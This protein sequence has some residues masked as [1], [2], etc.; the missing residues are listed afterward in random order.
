M[1]LDSSSIRTSSKTQMTLW[2]AM[3]FKTILPADPG[4]EDVDDPSYSGAASD[5]HARQQCSVDASVQKY[6]PST[7]G[8]G[9]I[10]TRTICPIDLTWDASDA[11]RRE[12]RSKFSHVRIARWPD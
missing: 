9:L 1:A 12:A 11:I 7:E 8:R 2:H 10:T 6:R 5:R 3:P 4:G